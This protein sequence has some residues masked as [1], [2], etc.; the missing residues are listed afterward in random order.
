MAANNNLVT[1]D[2]NFKNVYADKIEN[3]HP[4]NTK[5]MQRV[6]FVKGQGQIGKQ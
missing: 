6:P 3:L 1:L 4:E 2:G 5:L